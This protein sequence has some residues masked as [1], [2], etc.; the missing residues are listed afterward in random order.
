VEFASLSPYP[1]LKVILPLIL[2]H[3]R[4]NTTIIKQA[5]GLFQDL[6]LFLLGEFSISV[7]DQLDWLSFIPGHPFSATVAG[8]PFGRAHTS[9]QYDSPFPVRVLYLVEL[10]EARNS[11][12]SLLIYLP[13]P[14]RF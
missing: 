11:F 2:S 7:D 6:I 10:S 13:D 14:G 12:Y 4:S 3:L 9:Q 5:V 1:P 8:E